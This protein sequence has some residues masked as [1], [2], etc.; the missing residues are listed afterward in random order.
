MKSRAPI[1]IEFSDRSIHLLHDGGGLDVPLERDANGRITDASRAVAVNTLR[2][3]LSAEGAA[4]ERNAFCA[5]SARGVSIRRLSIPMSATEDAGRLIMLQLEA[6]LPI[7]PS[8]LAWGYMRVGSD[9]NPGPGSMAEYLV[10]VLKN[11]FL[12]APSSVLREAGIEA[13]FTVAALARTELW[14]SAVEAGSILEIGPRKSELTRFNPSGVE[15]VRVLPWGAE[16]P[17]EF[18]AVTSSLKPGER[19]LVGGVAATNPVR[20]ELGERAPQIRWESLN[21]E[22]GQGR[23]SATVG[24]QRLFERGVQPL[25]LGTRPVVRMQEKREGSWKWAIAAGLLLLLSLTLRYA[26]AAIYKVRVSQKLAQLTAYR[27]TL[28]N[29]DRE[30]S[31]LNYIKTNQPPYLETVAV[32]ANAAPPGTKVDALTLARH[33]DLSVRGTT[34]DL[35]APAAFRTKLIDS[36]FFSRVVIEEQSPGENNQAKFR[37]SAQVKPDGLRKPLALETPKGAA[38]NQPAPK[39]PRPPVATQLTRK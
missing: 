19:S 24:M 33:G 9:R 6:Q 31:L 3:F 22:P 12:A 17:D 35:N 27:A 36:G 34:G 25:L 26:E 16:T 21:L 1:F 18:A 37:I 39:E 2:G 11:E 4:G 13:Q 28:P 14:G 7:A 5:V 20:R 38:T 10:V 15:A 8:E 23:S 32:V 29:I 30:L